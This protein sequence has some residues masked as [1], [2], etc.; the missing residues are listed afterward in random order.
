MTPADFARLQPT[1][2]ANRLRGAVAT[3]VRVVVT[4]VAF[5]T[6]LHNLVPTDGLVTN[7]KQE[8][9]YTINHTTVRHT[10]MHMYNPSY[11]RSIRPSSAGGCC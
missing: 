11:P 9:L 6:F 7:W 1:L 3:G 2:D 4:H 10:R 8:P 5:L